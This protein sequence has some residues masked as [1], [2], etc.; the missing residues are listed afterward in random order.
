MLLDYLIQTY[1]RSEDVLQT[2][3]KRNELESILREYTER[4]QYNYLKEEYG[5]VLDEFLQYQEI[6]LKT[7]SDD[8][9]KKKVEEFNGIKRV[10][11]KIR[12][13]VNYSE[14]T[15]EDNFNNI[16]ELIPGKYKDYFK[17]VGIDIIKAYGCEE[18]K[19]KKAWMETV[20]NSEIK[21]DV[22]SE[23]YK[24][25]KVGQ[26]YT[27]SDIKDS[28]NNLYQRLGYQ[29]KAKATDLELYYIM[30]YV[31]FQDSTNK[32]VNGFELIGKR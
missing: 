14:D 2:Q 25:F 9:I 18:S 6:R 3:S 15:S 26:R 23:I 8:M 22:I 4:N 11:D 12:Y 28:L 24:M 1:Y 31:K 32:W 29:K 27:K 19:I 21:D 16:L 20:S 30:K 5:F 17:I 10:N 13:L 7:C